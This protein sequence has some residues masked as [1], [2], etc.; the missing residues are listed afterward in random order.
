MEE[1]V[2]QRILDCY[3]AAS[4]EGVQDAFELAQEIRQRYP[5][6][7]LSD[8]QLEG[9]VLLIEEVLRPDRSQSSN[10]RVLLVQRS[11]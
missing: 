5:R 4:D 6:C 3:Q 11:V 10:D 2:A 7:P 8:S 9:A 1:A